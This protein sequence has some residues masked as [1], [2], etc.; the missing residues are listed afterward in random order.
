MRRRSFIQGIA[1]FTTWPLVAHAQQPTLP[2]I[3][4]LSSASRVVDDVRRLPG[5]RKVGQEGR[6]KDLFA[7]LAVLTASLVLVPSQTAWGKS[8]SQSQADRAC[9]S[10]GGVWLDYDCG[11]EQCS[12]CLVC[13]Q[14]RGVQRC[15]YI[16]C[17][18]T[19]CVST[20]S[21]GGINP[22]TGPGQ[23]SG[24]PGVS[25]PPSGGSR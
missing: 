13:K 21:R 14:V 4:F 23:P 22:G 10:G 11:G 8:V 5:F 1:A 25:T 16:D 19:R 18:S 15:T 6:M 20:T 2:V 17:S 3:G 24:R 9:S 7:I 12:E